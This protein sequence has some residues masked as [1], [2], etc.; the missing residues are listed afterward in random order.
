M[1]S[2]RLESTEVQSQ[3]LCIELFRIKRKIV[4][5]YSAERNYA[6]IQCVFSF[7]KVL[8]CVVKHPYISRDPDR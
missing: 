6:V 1:E 4:E 5:I 3:K 7:D 8:I 2:F